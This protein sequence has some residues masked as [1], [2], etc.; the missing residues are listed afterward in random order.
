MW[1]WMAELP[2]ISKHWLSIHFRI[3]FT[4]LGMPLLW[5]CSVLTS[6]IASGAL[7]SHWVCVAGKFLLWSLQLGSQ[8]RS[9]WRYDFCFFHSLSILAAVLMLLLSIVIKR[10]VNESL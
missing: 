5:Y 7:L 2:T 8:L 6:V 4:H 3:R 9:F 10:L 1:F